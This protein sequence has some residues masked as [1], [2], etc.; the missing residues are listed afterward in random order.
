[1]YLDEKQDVE[2][3]AS[4]VLRRYFTDNDVDYLV[5][6]FTPDIVWLGAGKEQKAEGFDAVSRHFRNEKN[7]LMHCRMWDESYVTRKLADDC[8]LCEVTSELESVDP[9]VLFRIRQRVSFIFKRIDGALKIAHI[10]HSAAYD[11]IQPDELFPIE[12]ARSSY[13]ELT[14]LLT[15]KEQQIELMLHQI[16]GGTMICHHDERYRFKWVSENFYRMMGFDSELELYEATDGAYASLVHPDDLDKLVEEVHQSKIAHVASHFEY[17]MIKK[18]GD[19]IWVHDVGRCFTDLDGDNVTSCFV[20]DITRRIERDAQ[21]KDTRLEISRKTDFLSQLYD[22]IPCGIVQMSIDSGHR[23]INANRGA[24]EIFGYTRDEYLQ[25]K[26]D[27]FLH[28][29][30]RDKFWIHKR[31]DHL[32]VNGGSITYEREAVKKDG[33]TGWISVTIERLFNF[34]GIEVLQAVYSDISEVKKLQKEQEQERAIEN[35]SLRAAIYTAYQLIIRV[36]LTQDTYEALSERDYVVNYEPYGYFNELMEEVENGLHPDYRDAYIGT[37]TRQR[38]IERFD[39]GEKEIYMEYQ[40]MGADGIYHWVSLTGIRIDNPYN[41]DTLCIL[42]TKVLDEQRA[43]QAVQEQVLKNALSAARMA[44]Q[45]KSDFLSRMSHDIRTPLNAIIGMSTISQLKMKEPEVLADCLS[46]IDVSSRYLLSLINDIL[47][48]SRIESGKMALSSERFDFVELIG[49]IN[50]IVYPQAVAGKLAYQIH[51]HESLDRY[52]E[53]DTLRI[54]QILMN[55]LSNAV[56]FTPEGGKIDVHISESRRSNGFAYIEFRV[57]DTGIGMSSDFMKRLYLP[58][59]Q[60]TDDMARN[61]VGSGLGLSIVYSLVQI[62]GG[63]IDAKSEKNRGTTFT[64]VIPLRLAAPDGDGDT[65]IAG[66]AKE[67]LLDKHILIVDTETSIGEQ[68]AAILERIGAK[69]TC[70][71]SGSDAVDV[72]KMAME[73]GTPFDI[74]LIDWKMK[75]MNGSELTRRIRQFAPPEKTVI[76]VTAYDWSIFELDARAAGVNYFMAKPFFTSSFCETLLQLER[77]HRLGNRKHHEQTYLGRRFLLVEDNEL[78]M[79]IS[80]ALMEING[81][82]VETA[83]NGKVAV[84]KFQSFPSGHFAAIL[85]DIRMPVLNGLDA[86]RQIRTL[87]REDAKTIPVIAMSANAFDEDKKRAFDAG[88]NDYLVKPIDIAK[89]LSTLE[90]WM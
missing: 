25:E 5:S 50:T 71:F 29:L 79:E 67:L 88:I 86:T 21:E 76:V 61:K 11:P 57:S 81:M 31:V 51:Q 26:N 70:V 9:G 55:L 58:F 48:M 16:P 41:D 6:L 10:H 3:L 68:A 85:M 12:A 73:Q 64:V 37:F 56:K 19:I 36:N 17:R 65:E 35:R 42:L 30:D 23:I 27:P 72:V 39:K 15:E 60:E 40:R 66:K 80:K 87:P 13:E 53:G 47:D 22:T 84:E 46:K 77:D 90:K 69:T 34:D 78:N 7:V 32:A 59:E 75:D 63:T 14:R 33:S 38:M 89:L 20:S 18:N 2:N 28:V 74:A 54:N 43:E 1:M 45:A 8:Y 83:E 52:Y 24:W 62:M 44:N 4:S 82:E 49:S